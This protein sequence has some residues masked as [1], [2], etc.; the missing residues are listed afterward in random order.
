MKKSEKSQAKEKY[1]LTKTAKARR[2]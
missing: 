1:C 2:K